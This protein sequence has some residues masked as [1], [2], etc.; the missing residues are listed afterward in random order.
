[1]IG[2]VPGVQGFESALVWLRTPRVSVDGG[3]RGGFCHAHVVHQVCQVAGDAPHVYHSTT[4]L[5]SSAI[6]HTLFSIS[7]VTHGRILL[8]HPKRKF[9]M[10][11]YVSCL[12]EIGEWPNV[13][14]SVLRT[15]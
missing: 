6:V 13:Y 11:G 5:R 10:M 8:T 9:T 3:T 4:V 15:P 1:M 2:H 14:R 12:G 7:H